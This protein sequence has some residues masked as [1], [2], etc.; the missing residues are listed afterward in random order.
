M[1]T[2]GR[3]RRTAVVKETGGIPLLLLPFPFS[4]PCPG[5]SLFLQ[6]YALMPLNRG[7]SGDEVQDY[8]YSF[9]N[10]RRHSN[11]SMQETSGFKTKFETVEP[12]PVFEEDMHG[13]PTETLIDKTPV[14]KVE[15]TS[16]GTSGSSEAERAADE[17]LAVN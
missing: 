3:P 14:A 4:L 2:P 15:S 5:R 10:S 9:M 11:S 13:P 6:E 1:P 8:E 16:S 17:K 7:R 12:E